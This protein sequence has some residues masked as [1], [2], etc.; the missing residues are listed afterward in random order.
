MDV[1]ES[2]RE[3]ARRRSGLMGGGWGVGGDQGSCDP[4]F[5]KTNWL[6]KRRKLNVRE[7][8][9]RSNTAQ[10]CKW[11]YWWGRGAGGL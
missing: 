2:L 5:I 8:N 10:R 11:F 4:H 1:E 7:R 3:S 6:D 9:M